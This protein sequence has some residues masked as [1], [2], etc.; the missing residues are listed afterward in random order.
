[1]GKRAVAPGP[2]DYGHYYSKTLS[3][4]QY[5]FER[6]WGAIKAQ[7]AKPLFDDKFRRTWNYYLLFCKAAFDVEDL[8]LWQIVMS[9]K[10]LRDSVYG[11]VHL[12]T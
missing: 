5:N 2:A 4:W 9:K 11:R 1:M 3:A 10:G 6:N 7:K 12:H 8:Q